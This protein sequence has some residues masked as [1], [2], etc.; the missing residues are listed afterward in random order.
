MIIWKEFGRNC[1]GLM[2][3]VAWKFPGGTWGKIA[4]IPAVTRTEH[5]PDTS[6]ERFR[7]ASPVGMCPEVGD[8]PEQAAQYHILCL[9]A[10]FRQMAG[11]GLILYYI[12]IITVITMMMMNTAAL[13]WAITFGIVW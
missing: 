13:F 4:D 10:S 3:V 5:L 12:I 9:R 6:Q 8:K 7:Y 1:R 11:R 2:E